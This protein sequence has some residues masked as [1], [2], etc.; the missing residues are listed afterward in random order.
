MKREQGLLQVLGVTI[1]VKPVNDFSALH[2][3]HSVGVRHD[4]EPKIEVEL[5]SH[6]GQT[7]L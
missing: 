4:R 1:H 7:P 2:M 6:R 3:L 5:D